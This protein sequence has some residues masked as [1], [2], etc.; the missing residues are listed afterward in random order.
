MWGHG[1]TNNQLTTDTGENSESSAK[2]V[3]S[4]D[5]RNGGVSTVGTG[6]STAQYQATLLCLQS[7][8]VVVLEKVPSEGS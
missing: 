7:A 3:V 8:M 5:S 1:D 2:V 6:P 4:S